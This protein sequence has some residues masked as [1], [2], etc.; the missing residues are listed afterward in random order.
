MH[1]RR[2]ADL[3]EPCQPTSAAKPP[4]GPGWI[5]EIKYDGY[6]MMAA[7]AAGSTRLITRN[8]HDWAARYPLVV[9]AVDALWARSCIIDGELVKCDERGLAVFDLLRTGPRAKIDVALFAFDLLELNG[10]DLRREPI[11]A[12]KARLTK[13]LRHSDPNVRHPGRASFQS[14][15]DTIPTSAIQFVDYIGEDGPTVFAHACQLGCEGIVSKRAG[16]IY[17]S[18]RSDKWIKVKNPAAPA[19]RREREEDWNGGR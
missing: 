3:P 12:R 9:A 5:H 6:R 2:P 11:E 13:L 4:S 15:A 1:P 18:G 17:I 16:S 7:R 8:G 19:V 10:E 14:S